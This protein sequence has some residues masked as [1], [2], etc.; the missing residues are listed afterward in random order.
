MSKADYAVSLFN[1]G[2]NASQAFQAAFCPDLGIEE[3]TALKLGAGLSGRVKYADDVCGAV[4]SGILII[5]LRFGNTDPDDSASYERT[6]S[7]VEE[8][9][10]EFKAR[11][12]TIKCSE[13]LGIDVSTENGK[14]TAEDQRLLADVCS[15]LVRDSAEILEMIL[16]NAAD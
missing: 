3:D 4:I 6:Y 14:E 9:V 8:F 12:D 5:G 10:A 15:N 1:G 11:N 2:L 16:G 13:I 7:A